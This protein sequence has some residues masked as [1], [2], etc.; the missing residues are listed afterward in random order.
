MLSG[1]RFAL[2]RAVTNG[3]GPRIV[4]HSQRQATRVCGP[5]RALWLRIGE[6]APYPPQE[7][8]CGASL[9]IYLLV[10]IGEPGGSR[11]HD[12]L[13]KSQMLYQPAVLRPHTNNCFEFTMRVSAF[14]RRSGDLP[15]RSRC[16]FLA[17]VESPPASR[18]APAALPVPVFASRTSNSLR[19]VME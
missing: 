12:P 16:R 15:L 4:T 14:R 2:L 9:S 5:D 11:T 6:Q 1:W 8:A 13:I 10:L 18:P 3:S 7:L 19:R 17:P